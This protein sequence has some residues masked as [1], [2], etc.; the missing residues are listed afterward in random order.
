VV[1]QAKAAP[2]KTAI[3]TTEYTEYTE[4]ESFTKIMPVT[5][6]VSTSRMMQWEAEE[7]TLYGR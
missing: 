3:Q 7:V 5:L 1:L 4:K 6:W 2:A